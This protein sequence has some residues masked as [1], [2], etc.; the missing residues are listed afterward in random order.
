VT[1]QEE[2]DAIRAVAQATAPLVARLDAL[3]PRL[4][5]LEARLKA[6]EDTYLRR[7]TLGRPR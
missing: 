3:A 5:E 2:R 4:K 7:N 1:P 6:V